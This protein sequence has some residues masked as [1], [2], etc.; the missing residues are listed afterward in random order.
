VKT[1][2]WCDVCGMETE[3]SQYGGYCDYCGKFLI[4]CSLCDMDKVN[5]SECELA[6]QD[7]IYPQYKI[8]D[9]GECSN[10]IEW[11][12][13][14]PKL[15]MKTLY[16]LYKDME[17]IS[18]CGK[19]TQCKQFGDDFKKALKNDLG[20]DY[21]VEI[22]I[23]H[24]YISGFVN[25]IGTDKFVYFSVEDLRDDDKGFENVL[26]RSAKSDTDYSG[27]FNNFCKLYEL[28]KK[29]VELFNK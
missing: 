16:N 11:L 2:E 19:S 25:K 1:T 14:K 28:D 12:G 23:G 22:S 5:C 10:K 29:I 20:T 7:T 27:G 8:V 13:K 6:W 9:D 18:T 15:S 17:F 24:F 4:P 21:N 26:Y 3:I